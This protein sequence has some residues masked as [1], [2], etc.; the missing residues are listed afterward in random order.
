[1]IKAHI[2]HLRQKVELDPGKPRF[3]L[4]VPGVG[5][6]LEYRQEDERGP[7][8]WLDRR[9]TMDAI[10]GRYKVR[11]EETGLVMRHP[12]GLIFDFR[13]KRGVRTLAFHRLL[14]R[15]IY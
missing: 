12:T 1:M 3:L 4:T 7:K 2:R 10:I 5:Y 13:A 8:R 9:Q 15:V 14:P 6:T 11:M